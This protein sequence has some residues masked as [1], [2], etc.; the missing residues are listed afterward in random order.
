VAL[1]SAISVNDRSK[2]GSLLMRG[3][4]GTKTMKKRSLQTWFAEA[5][6]SARRACEVSVNGWPGAVFHEVEKS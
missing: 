4:R 5:K 2:S 1:R 6:A 3:R